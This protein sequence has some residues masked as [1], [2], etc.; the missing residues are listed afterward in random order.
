MSKW[1]LSALDLGVGDYS[2]SNPMNSSGSNRTSM[3][4]LLI[5]V[6]GAFYWQPNQLCLSP[7][8]M[9]GDRYKYTFQD[10]SNHV[11]N[12]LTFGRNLHL[13]LTA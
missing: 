13:K 2:D 6:T 9:K 7:T 5:N 11:H 10:N 12:Q 1:H 4:N 3:N 8:Q